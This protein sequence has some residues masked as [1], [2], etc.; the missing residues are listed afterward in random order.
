MSAIKYR[1]DIDG[2][3]ALAILPI[4]LFHAQVPNTDGGYIGVDIFY[5]ISGYLITRIL[6]ANLASGNFSYRDFYARRIRRLGPALAAM[7]TGVLILSTLILPPDALSETAK[8]AIAVT[9]FTSNFFF[10]L[11]TGSYFDGAAE[12]R[13][14]LHTWSLAVEE[15]FYII[16]PLIFISIRRIFPGSLKLATVL[17]AGLS[18]AAAEYF[19]EAYPK[20]VFYLL[21]TRA[22]ELLAGCMLAQCENIPRPTKVFATALAVSGL[23]LIAGPILIYSESTR[24][25]GVA[26]LPPVAGTVLLIAFSESTFVGRFLANP[27]LVRIGRASYS[28][29]LWHWPIAVFVRSSTLEPFDFSQ[30]VAIVLA[31]VAIGGLSWQFIE[32]R[33]VWKAERSGSTVEFRSLAAISAIVISV[34]AV[35]WTTNGLAFREK[36]PDAG[37]DRA[38]EAARQLQRSTCLMRDGSLPA[39]GCVLGDLKNQPPTAALWGDSHAAQLAPVVDRWGRDGGVGIHQLTKAGCAPI[40]DSMFFP[41]DRMRRDCAQF[42]SLAFEKIVNDPMI[43]NVIIAGRWDAFTSGFVRIDAEKQSSKESSI[44]RVGERIHREIAILE[45]KGK[46]VTLI[47]QVPL[48]KI[49]I[50]DCFER[51]TF[52]NADTAVCTR[53]DAAANLQVDEATSEML[54]VR[55]FLPDFPG[56]LS[57][58]KILCNEKNCN[59]YDGHDFIYMDSDHL[60]PTG[61]ARI[62]TM[63]PF[64]KK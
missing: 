59:T 30:T 22:W 56:Y 42:N 63:N 31:S 19:I 10:A 33:F 38:K 43:K 50:P 1:P 34:C 5:V 28:I 4:L 49:N 14:L 37:V 53:L 36:R 3:R 51:R 39:S 6:L 61:A 40:V 21:P 55:R 24:F 47:G 35:M 32:K 62:L 57:P 7:I 18:L 9:T 29:Y 52:L 12:Y 8:S 16:F 60:S 25:P 2:M 41:Q 26:A 44:A 64:L 27:F 45:S 23:L 58:T 54:Q 11:A 15:Q 13:P 46:T 17:I 48:P 20:A